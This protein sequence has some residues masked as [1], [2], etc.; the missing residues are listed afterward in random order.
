MRRLK[1][2]SLNYIYQCE[3]SQRTIPD[4]VQEIVNLEKEAEELYVL[5]KMRRS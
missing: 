2:R 3:R 5:M 4:M 1:N